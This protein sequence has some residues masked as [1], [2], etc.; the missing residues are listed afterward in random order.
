VFDCTQPVFQ[1]E[2]SENLASK[3]VS[4]AT[5]KPGE[6]VEAIRKGVSENSLSPVSDHFYIGL[7]CLCIVSQK[8]KGTKKEG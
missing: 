6:H 2:G 5:K 8:N 3:V 4:F 7:L 1:K